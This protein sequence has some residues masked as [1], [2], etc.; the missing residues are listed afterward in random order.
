MEL[1]YQAAAHIRL[2]C[3][4]VITLRYIILDRDEHSK[5]FLDY[6]ALDAYKI[7]KAYLQ[8][9]SQTAKP[10]HVEAMSLQQAELERCVAEVRGRYT[11]VGRKGKT[12]EFGNWCNL[13]LKDQAD[14]CGAEMQKLY[15]LGYRQLS[16]Y[17]HGSAWALRRQD[18]YIRAGYDQTV[19]MIDFATLTR[20]LLAVWVEWLKIMSEEL[21]W[22]TLGRAHGIMD[23]CNELDETTV[24]VVAKIRKREA[25]AVTRSG[26]KAMDGEPRCILCDEPAGEGSK[27]FASRPRREN[28]LRARTPMPIL[29]EFFFGT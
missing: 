17:V 28:G 21:D 22:Q 19:V 18:A 1:V 23:R 11:Y 16:A 20:T 2:F 3:E 26:R 5:A 8:W 25:G 10:Q 15:A 29:K 14:Q 13:T 7:G 6:A 4:S 24:Q 27:S 9:E 12:R